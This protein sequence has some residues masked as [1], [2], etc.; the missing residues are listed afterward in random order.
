MSNPV[1]SFYDLHV[2]YEWHRL[3]RHRM[4]FAIA[5]KALEEYLPPSG[6]VIDIG[7]GP[8]RYS[9][10]LASKGYEVTL[11][12]LSAANLK[13]ATELSDARPTPERIRAFIHANAVDLSV[14]PDARFDA[15]LL[16]GPLY[17][18]LKE[19]ERRAAVREALRILKPG[20]TLFA[21]FIARYAP[22]IDVIVGDPAWLVEHNE[23]MEEFLVFGFQTAERAAPFTSFY[24]A[25]PADV[26][27][28]MESCGASTVTLLAQEGL[29]AGREQEVN[30][31]E[32]S[33]WQKWVDLNYRLA[34][35]LHLLA[36]A[37]HL[38]YVGKKP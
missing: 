33:A 24:T 34:S 5:A 37:E 18:L 13:R 31:L 2:D 7:G 12:D 9:L 22:I 21:S 35:D 4:E 19:D 15:A 14:L 30:K 36:G 28:F 32:G 10:W 1:E 29:A 6:S 3:E 16:M 11:A 20:G 17:H 25:H 27:P 8:G 23:E 38:L 26:E